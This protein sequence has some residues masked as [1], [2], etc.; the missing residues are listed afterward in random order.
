MLEQIGWKTEM[1]FGGISIGIGIFVFCFLPET[2]G[3]S[4]EHMTEVILRSRFFFT[5]Q[6]V[7]LCFL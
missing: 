2:R 3:V 1:I 6:S 5:G 4:L 7:I